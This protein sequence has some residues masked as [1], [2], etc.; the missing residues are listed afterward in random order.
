MSR[1][2]KPRIRLGDRD[3]AILRFIGEQRTSWLEAIHGRFYDDRSIEAARSTMRR[4]CGRPPNFRFVRVEQLDG[5]RNF[6]RLTARGAK[7]IGAPAA[8]SG[9]LGR[10]A[11]LRRY[12]LQW[13]I[14]VDGKESRWH[15]NPRDYPDLFPVE[16]QRLPRANFY[17]EESSAGTML[18]FAI[19]DY[20]TDSRR[21]SR[22]A[23]DLL[24]RFLVNRW[25]DELFAAK[26][27]GVTFLMATQEKAA[28]IEHQF[29]RDSQR[30]LTSHLSQ[31]SRNEPAVILTGYV[32]VPGLLALIPPN[33][34]Q[35][36][37]KESQ[38]D[39]A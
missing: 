1:K 26:R 18:G 15:C 16:G 17:L 7:V 10:T 22:R 19:E 11:L 32:V 13:Y 35:A 12:A 24:E 21:V 8:A 5:S 28:A 9:P 3:L 33:S 20:G 29:Q 4:L 6:F 31:I 38:H 39:N 34:T 36:T 25:F 2:R 37:K 23:V 14:E 27:F 30:R